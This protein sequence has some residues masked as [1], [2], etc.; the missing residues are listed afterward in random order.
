[1]PN[2]SAR[3]R[4]GMIGAALGTLITSLFGTLALVQVQ[5]RADVTRTDVTRD[6]SFL[7]ARTSG[8]CGPLITK[9]N[10][11]SW[12]CTFADNFS[13]S[14][15]N[16]TK[17]SPLLTART[18]IHSP[19]C[20]VATPGTIRVARG[21]LKLTVRDKAAQFDCLTPTGSYPTKYVGGGITSYGKFNQAYGRFEIRAKFPSAKVRGLH[22]ALWM[23]PQE[24]VYG[25]WPRSGEID[26]AEY[27]TAL[28]GRV[29]PTLHYWRS[30]QRKVTTNNFC[31]PG[32]A[33]R[34]HTYTLTW[35]RRMMTITFDG[36]VCLIRRFSLLNLILSRRPFD[37]PFVLILNQ[38]LGIFQNSVTSQTPLPATMNIDYV[39]VW[40]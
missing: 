29:I 13:G 39:R 12:Q 24:Q 34:F 15:L 26:I 1:M 38:S 23:F 10:G 28:P 21:S 16:P 20:R 32:R 31:S 36:R 9:P 22:S 27:R 11:D 5:A 19:E 37:H 4:T 14:T 7:A 35:S 17:W 25:A 18:G 40:K 8:G 30:G 2:S 3:P 6:G 33:D